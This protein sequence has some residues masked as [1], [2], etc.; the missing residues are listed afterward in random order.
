LPTKQKEDTVMK[1]F[2]VVV[3]REILLFKK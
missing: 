3:T 2:G 1:S